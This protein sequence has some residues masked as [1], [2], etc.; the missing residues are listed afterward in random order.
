MWVANDDDP[1]CQGLKTSRLGGGGCLL[2]FL[3]LQSLSQWLLLLLGAIIP[4]LAVNLR[5]H[6][7]V[8]VCERE[9]ETGRAAYVCILEWKRPQTHPRGEAK[10]KASGTPERAQQDG[11]TQGLTSRSCPAR[12]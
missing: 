12:R 1:G 10:L 2:I 4:K 7:C 5:K 8:C 3:E 11:Q 9:R 6:V